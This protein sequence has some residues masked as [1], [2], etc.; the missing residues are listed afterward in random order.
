LEVPALR[1]FRGILNMNIL[2]GPSTGTIAY[3]AAIC[4]RGALGAAVVSSARGVV[5]GYVEPSVIVDGNSLPQ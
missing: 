5:S 1:E 3:E 2:A 4:I